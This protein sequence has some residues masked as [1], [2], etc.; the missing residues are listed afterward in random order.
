[1]WIS[2][3][4]TQA[5][6]SFTASAKGDLL[7]RANT[8]STPPSRARKAFSRPPSP[9]QSGPGRKDGRSWRP[10]EGDPGLDRGKP[11]EAANA[12]PTSSCS[13]GGNRRNLPARD[14]QEGATCAGLDRLFDRR[15]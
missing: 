1:M 14:D 15:Q 8:V 11:A 5:S 13:P 10:V 9:R 4:S 2:V 3:A 12:S 7:S 6:A